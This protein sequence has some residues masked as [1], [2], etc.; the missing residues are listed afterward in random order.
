MARQAHKI[1]RLTVKG[2]ITLPKPMR[3]ALGWTPRTRLTFLRE[4]DG[5]RIVR[6]EQGV[7][8]G[9]AFVRQFRGTQRGKFATN[10]IM[11]MTRGED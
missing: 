8:V 10:A 7:D 4:K 5:I 2:Q 1:G 11:A 6:V 3:D 9:E